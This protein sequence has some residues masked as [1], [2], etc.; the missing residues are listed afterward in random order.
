MYDQKWVDGSDLPN[1]GCSSIL[2]SVD[3]KMAIFE[4]KYPVMYKQ[5][6]PEKC[7]HFVR[8]ARP[9]TVK[10]VAALKKNG[11][12][13]LLSLTYN[14]YWLKAKWGLGTKEACEY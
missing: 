6:D 1:L 9:A 10:T 4:P 2:Q 12:K 11:F 3:K 5:F 8:V 14:S 7:M 13:R